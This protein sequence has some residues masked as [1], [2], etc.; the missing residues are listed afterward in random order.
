LAAAPA[1]G[2]KIRAKGLLHE[3]GVEGIALFGFRICPDGFEE[4]SELVCE[5]LAGDEDGHGFF[6]PG[7]DCDFVAKDADVGGSGVGDVS[8]FGVAQLGEE[9]LVMAADKSAGGEFFLVSVGV[10]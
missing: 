6:A 3:F 4:F 7:L 2:S 10:I 8:D 9:F 1:A 5:F